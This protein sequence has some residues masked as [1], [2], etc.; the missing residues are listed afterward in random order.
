MSRVSSQALVL[1]RYL[2]TL[3]YGMTASYLCPLW[4]CY[5]LSVPFSCYSSLFQDVKW[6]LIIFYKNYQRISEILDKTSRTTDFCTY[7]CKVLQIGLLQK[8]SLYSCL[9]EYKLVE[10]THNPHNISCDSQYLHPPQVER[11]DKAHSAASQIVDV[12]GEDIVLPA[13][14]AV[15]PRSGSV[16]SSTRRAQASRVVTVD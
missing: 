8:T 1:T 9:Q 13:N 12:E 7:L 5:L 3:H 10:S 6:F 4:S 15:R 2:A 11:Q 16:R 14:V